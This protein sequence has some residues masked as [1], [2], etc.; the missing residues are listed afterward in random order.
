MILNF[1]AFKDVQPYLHFSFKYLKLVLVCKEYQVSKVLMQSLK[2]PKCTELFF[3]LY[4]PDLNTVL[5]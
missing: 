3:Q 4:F 1:I 2:N 5:T